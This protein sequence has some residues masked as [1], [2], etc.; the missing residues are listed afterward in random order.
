M[1][2]GAP[3][4]GFRLAYDRLGSGDP[5]V[6]L[7]GWPGDHT[8]YRRVL[9]LLSD[10]CEVVVPDLRGFGASDRHPADPEQQYDARA[11][12][13]GVAGLI[14]ELG[15]D[16]PVLAGYDIGSRIA[17]AVA[18]DHPG[19]VRA[20]VVAPPLPGIGDRI[21]Q[22]R[23]QREFWYQSFHQLALAEEL[24]DG[25][26]VALRAY[27]RHFWNHWSGPS[28]TLDEAALEHLVTVYGPPGAFSASIAWYRAGAGAVAA[29]LGEVPPGAGD[30]IAV[31][32][33]VLWPEHDPLFPR[34]WSDRLSGFFADVSVESVAG[35]GHFIPV[36]APSR[37]AAAIRR[38]LE[39]PGWAYGRN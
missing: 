20:L 2:R 22:P 32:A 7:H 26:P 19:L 5:V 39:R 10:G 13:R 3:V 35:A 12:A 36:E 27:L 38:V 25:D 24:L 8:D 15:L 31:P 6:L 30:R 14:E 9:P 11:Q 37:F 34:S 28:F 23:A 21:L 18:R 33:T 17:Q 29:S 1:E 16:R 4:D